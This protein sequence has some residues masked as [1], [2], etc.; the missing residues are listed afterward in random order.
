MTH[1]YIYMTHTHIYD[2]IHTYILKKCQLSLFTRPYV[3]TPC[4]IMWSVY[5]KFDA[6]SLGFISL[7]PPKFNH[8]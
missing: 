1:I 6:F 3:P 2:M 8:E 5:A 7:A 4:Y